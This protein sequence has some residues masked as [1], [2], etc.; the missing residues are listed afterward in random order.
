MK[1]V[2]LSQRIPVW[3]IEKHLTISK[4]Q[5]LSATLQLTMAEAY[6]LS[7][8]GLNSLYDMFNRIV[9]A[10]P[11]GYIIHKQDYYTPKEYDRK[12]QGGTF[13]SNSYECMFNERV[14]LEHRCYLIITKN[15]LVDAFTTN[16][17][18][19]LI[20]G[21]LVK[22]DISEGLEEFENTLRKQK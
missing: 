10:L 11:K 13:L 16:L 14:F 19:T 2:N 5:A 18:T 6:S 12:G 9:K 7:E 17:I 20:S 4:S 22:R 3:K 21:R 15:P 8:E 1:N